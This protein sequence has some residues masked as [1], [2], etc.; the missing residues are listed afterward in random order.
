MIIPKDVDFSKLSYKEKAELLSLLEEIEARNAT[1]GHLKKIWPDEGPLAWH[2]YPVH[3]EFLAAGAK[4][5][6][7]FFSAGNR[8]LSEGTLVATPLGPTPIEEIKVGDFVY[9]PDGNPTK[10]LALWDNGYRETV[11]LQCRNKEY[12]QCTPDH[13]IYCYVNPKVRTSFFDESTRSAKVQA[14]ELASNKKAKRVFPKCPL[15]DAHEPGA[16]ALGALLGDG[17]C[18]ELGT[19]IAISSHDDKIPT[20]IMND[21]GGEYIKRSHPTNY[22]WFIKAEFPNHYDD[23]CRGRYAHEKTVDMSVVKSWD[24]ESLLNFVAG[25]LDTDGSLCKSRDGYTL[26]LT[27]QAVPVIQAFEY[28]VL[29]LWGEP[30]TISMDKRDRYVNGQP[31]T[32]TVRNPWAVKRI[33]EELRHYVVHSYKTDIGDFS[34]VGKRSFPNCISLTP[35]P[36]SVKRVYDI[37]VAHPLHLY[38]LAN[39]M[40]VSNCGKTLCGAYEAACHLSGLYPSWWVGKRF[41][42]P[43]EMWAAGDTSATCRDILQKE[44]LGPPGAEGTGMVAQDLIANIKKKAGVPD[45]IESFKVKHVSGGWSYCG[46]KSYDQGR[47][48]FQGTAKH[49]IFLDEEPPLDVYGECLIRTTTTDGSIIVTA[50]PLKGLTPFVQSFMEQAQKDMVDWHYDIEEE[51]KANA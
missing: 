28:A 26:T 25:L 19:R 15:G 51:M 16:Y 18:R 43:I 24:R 36:G 48:S 20:R 38:L 46:F 39:G 22:T 3:M 50:T 32:A 21:L 44:L 12:L 6:E 14:G 5:R 35:K 34:G 13:E 9:G 41:D 30:V 45:G 8:C 11:S 4:F 29:A 49:F 37:T 23:W 2:Q 10:V 47:R 1:G 40:V 33:C 17:C 31:Y 7:R 42:S 27:M